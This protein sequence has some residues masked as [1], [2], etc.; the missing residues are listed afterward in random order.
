MD[1]VQF[2]LT[3]LGQAARVL[4][5][6]VLATNQ[7]DSLWRERRAKAPAHLIPYACVSTHTVC[8]CSQHKR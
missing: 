4:D 1:V 2:P 7:S 8:M 6:V 3:D 5:N